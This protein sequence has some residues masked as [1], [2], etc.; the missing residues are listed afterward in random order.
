MLDDE[1]VRGI[2][3]NYRDVTDLERARQ[4]RD[5]LFELTPD[6][7][8]IAG[9][10]G[11]FKRL[12]AAWEH[13]LGWTRDEMMARPYVDF[14]HADDR[15]VTK[16]THGAA[17]CGAIASFENRYR[18]R[19]GS[20]R[21][22]QWKSSFDPVTGLIY[23][24]ARDVTEKKRLD[25]QLHQAQKMEAVARL[26]GGVAHDINNM[27]SVIYASTELLLASMAEGEPERADIVEIQKVAERS[28]GLV[29]QLLAFGRKGPRAVRD[30][31][32]DDAVQS[33]AKMITRVVGD[34]IR[35]ETQALAG[36]TIHADPTELESV[37]MNLALNAR[38]AMAGSGGTIEITTELRQLGGTQASR[39]GI[40]PGVYVALSV[41]D[42]GCGIP[43]ALR[44]KIF[45]PFFTT[46]EIG[47][48]TGLGLATVFGIVQDSSGAVEMQS[49]E[50]SGSTF[51]VLFP[52]A[53]RSQFRNRQRASALGDSV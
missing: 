17:V 7:L 45:E 35:V 51:T 2:V 19:D 6:L 14:V 49:T 3:S 15:D 10:D 22:I 33:V 39:L 11:Y 28:A 23:A 20:Y 8:C 47:K 46:K 48:G 13:T 9:P 53:R 4:E 29:R 31:V 41:S 21:W 50:G 18:C 52:C 40:A 42:T 38:D 24:I 1:D 34:G 5:R 36:A 44:H 30:V 25:E 12:N 26:A 27:L 16:H 32:I 37:L 43:L